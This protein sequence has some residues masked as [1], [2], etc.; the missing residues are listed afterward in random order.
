[1]SEQGPRI[2]RGGDM[3]HALKMLLKLNGK[4]KYDSNQ[5]TTKWTNKLVYFRLFEFFLKTVSPWFRLYNVKFI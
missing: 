3:L 2:E 5:W 1:M 4:E